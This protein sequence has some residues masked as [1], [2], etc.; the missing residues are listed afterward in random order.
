MFWHKKAPSIK[1]DVKL[2]E[3]LLSRGVAEII[4]KEKLEASLHSGKALRVKLGIDPTSPNI[5]LGRAVVLWKLRA[6]QE[7]GH[8]IIFIIGDF[9]GVIGDSS[10]KESERPM[11]S[12]EVIS[13]NMKDYFSQAGKILD[14]S[15]VEKHHNSKWLSKL[16]FKE[17]NDLADKFS[18]SDFIARENIERRLSA[19]ARVSLREVLYPL[20]QGFDSVEV[21]SEVE[22][23]GTDQRFNMLAGR[24]LLT[25]YKKKP[26]QI[27]MTKLL[28]GLD[29]RKMSSS[30]GNTIN[31]KDSPSEMYGKGMSLKDELIPE[32][33]SLATKVSEKEV[34]EIE[35]S[36]KNGTLHPKDAKMRLARELVELYH[37]KEAALK[38]E[39]QFVN[40]FSKKEIPEDSATVEI[41]VGELLVDVFL[42]NKIVASKSEFA[43]LID[44]GAIE[45][46]PSGKVV[47]PK[48]L[49]EKSATYKIGKHRFLKTK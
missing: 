20:M 24:T 23:G 41:K 44:Q 43:R 5:H 12:P 40:T 49:A 14:M 11:L 6:F 33:F 19:G 22:I 18:L 39:A 4:D 15:K 1:T 45:I 35:E 26:Q 7:L 16:N 46:L 36:L 25:H 10:D 30:W 37:G 29:G 47:D 32:F 21:E 8:Q 28:R 13:E 9:T 34:I 48:A 2:I 27:I 42:Q 3:E 17:I 38:A 31:I